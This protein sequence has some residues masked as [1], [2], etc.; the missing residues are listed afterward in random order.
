LGNKGKYL[1][2]HAKFIAILIAIV[3]FLVGFLFVQLMFVESERISSDGIREYVQEYFSEYRY[4]YNGQNVPFIELNIT[5][6][7]NFTFGFR[8]FDTTAVISTTHGASLFFNPSQQGSSRFTVKEISDPIEYYVWPQMLRN[9]SGL[10]S[11]AIEPGDYPFD[12]VITVD[13]VLLYAEPGANLRCVRK[14]RPFNVT[15]NGAVWILGTYILEHSILLKGS[16]GKEDWSKTQADIDA[17]SEYLWDCKGTGMNAT[18]IQSIET[19]YEPSMLLDRIASRMKSGIYKNNQALFNSD[20]EEL[21]RAAAGTMNDM[22][23]KV[24]NDYYALQ[25]VSPESPFEQVGNYLLQKADAIIVSV[26][27]TAIITW[28]GVNRR[29]SRPRALA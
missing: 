8:N 14:D 2:K 25:Q 9:I 16:N 23:T 6:L 12:G 29:K 10:P 7:G 21:R 15:S 19:K 13:A 4:L 20:Y 17:L 11:I 18:T 22:L 5:D 28:F 26:V 27:T 3:V 24:L 1:K